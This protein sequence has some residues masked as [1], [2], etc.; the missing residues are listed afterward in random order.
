MVSRVTTCPVSPE[1]AA[2]LL[3]SAFGA[4]T[5]I[6]LWPPAG[7]PWQAVP[8]TALFLLSVRYRLSPRTVLRRAWVVW[9]FAGLVSVGLLVH[10]DWPL[11]AGNLFLKATFSLWTLSLLAHVTPLADLIAGLRRLGVPPI[12]CGTIAFWGRYYAVVNEEWRRLQLARRARTLT[13][14]RRFQFRGLANALGLLFI[15]SYERA[16]KV[17]RAMLA[18]GYRGFS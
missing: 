9:L 15:R 5:L 18:R 16:E 2:A 3:L 14:S 4:V 17:H 7:W 1:R 12:W 13:R 11:R 6:A 10:P 8:G